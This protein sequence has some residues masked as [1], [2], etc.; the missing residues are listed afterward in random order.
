LGEEIMLVDDEIDQ[1]VY[2]LN[3]LIE[4]EIKIIELDR[5]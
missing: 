4:E 1:R 5:N 2:E 3:G